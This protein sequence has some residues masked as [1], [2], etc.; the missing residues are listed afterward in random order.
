MKTM[1]ISFVICF[2]NSQLLAVSPFQGWRIGVLDLYIVSDLDSGAF[3][4]RAALHGF[5]V[6]LCPGLWLSR[7]L[8]GERIVGCVR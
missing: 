3:Q 1:L 4:P 7:P 5:A 8:W 6:S 2:F